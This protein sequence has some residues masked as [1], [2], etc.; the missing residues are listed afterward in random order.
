MKVRLIV[1][2]TGAS[3]L[4]AGAEADFP[5]DEARRLV[6]AGFAEPINPV[7]RAVKRRAKETR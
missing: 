3:Y 7:E 1:G 5:D 4:E 2:L 6:A